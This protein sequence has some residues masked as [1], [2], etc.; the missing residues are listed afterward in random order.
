MVKGVLDSGSTTESWSSRF[1]LSLGPWLG[2][3]CRLGVKGPSDG[4]LG[5]GWALGQS[6][7]WT[8]GGLQ[9][10]LPPSCPCPL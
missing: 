5:L 10:F 8:L 4:S 3:G 7:A 6:Q 1:I 9:S 2:G